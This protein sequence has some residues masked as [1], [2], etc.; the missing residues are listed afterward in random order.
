MYVHE[1][2]SRIA[3]RRALDYADLSIDVFVVRECLPRPVADLGRRKSGFPV[4]AAI[5][6]PWEFEWCAD[7]GPVKLLDQAIKHPCHMRIVVALCACKC[8]FIRL[9]ALYSRNLDLRY[10][11]PSWAIRPF[12]RR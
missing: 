3:L 5:P 6:E 12:D 4:L 10:G 11:I 2:Y 1:T 7:P 9:I 8:N